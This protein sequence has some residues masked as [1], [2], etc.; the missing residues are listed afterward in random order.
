[1]KSEVSFPE[2]PLNSRRDILI[3]GI[4]GAVAIAGYGSS[5]GIV[6]ASVPGVTHGESPG[7]EEG[8]FWVDGQ[9][10]RVD[11]RY[12]STTKV[13]QAGLPLYL[14]LTI[15]QLSDTS[16]YTITPLVGA[17]VDMWNA[18]AQGVYSDEASESTT[19]TDYLRGYQ[20]TNSHGVVNFLTNYPGW[21][22]GRTPHIHFRIRT[23]DS[24]G[25]VVYNYAS[26]VF[27][28]DSVTAT[29]FANNSAYS[30]TTAQDTTNTTDRV[31]TGS[32]TNGSPATEAGDYLL[33]KLA[34]N[35]TKATG[36]FH[37]VI[38]LSD[39]ANADPTNG[40]ENTT[41]TGTGGGGTP[42]SGGG[43]P[44]GGGTTAPAA[45]TTTTTTTTKKSK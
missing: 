1:M 12:D 27:F 26:Q 33:L 40:V 13:Y 3:K 20:V 38:D 4:A 23:Y 11:V 14:G 22:S 43:T 35:G 7:V 24:S 31:Y 17:R 28:S 41:S 21:Y 42:P 34:Q 10:N 39:S 29:V 45:R 16:P 2:R 18:N 44:P 25:N 9:V 37:Y 8:P 30:R 5:G 36:S 6:V 15:S 19:G 32:G